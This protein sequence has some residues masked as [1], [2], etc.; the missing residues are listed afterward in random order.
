MTYSLPEWLS[1][2]QTLHPKAI[3]LGLE[4]VEDVAKKLGVMTLPC[5]VVTIGGTNGKGSCVAF[6]EAIF[7]AQGYKVG[8]YTSPHLLKFNERIRMAGQEVMDAHLINAFVEVEQARGKVDLTYFEFTTLAALWLFQQ[9][10][11]DVVLLEIGLGGRLDAVNIMDSELAIVTTIALDHVDWLGDTREAI[12]AEKAG[13]F[14]RKKPAICGDFSPPKSVLAAAEQ[15]HTSLYCMNHDFYYQVQEEQT[16]VRDLNACTWNWQS[17]CCDLKQ[18]P[19]PKLPLQNAATALMGIELLQPILPVSLDSIHQGLMRAMILGRFQVLTKPVRIILDV[20]HNPAGAQWLAKQLDD[21]LFKGRTLAVVGM[22]NDKDISA[23]LTPL[24]P[25]V[26]RWYLAGLTEEPR[27]SSMEM[28]QYHLQSLGVR[29]YDMAN[30][31]SLAFKQA[32]ENCRP[33][34]RIVVFGSFHVVGPVLQEDLW[35]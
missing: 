25:H 13:I 9:A 34:D 17:A 35:S 26:D 1:Y 15:L 2:I 21:Q 20:A 10:K 33:Q 28:M 7:Q 11:L 29:D 27:G 4:R 5:P 31:V 16:S 19:M 32:L 18:L 14:R 22:L 24:L 6:L 30:S 23:T 3:A 12:G 8:A